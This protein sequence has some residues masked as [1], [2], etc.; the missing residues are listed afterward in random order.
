MTI[1]ELRDLFQGEY[2][3]AAQIRGGVK[4]DIGDKLLANFISQAQQ[5]IQRRLL[6][7][8]SSVDLTLASTTNVHSLPTNFGLHKHAYL[9]TS[10][11]EEKPARFMRELLAVGGTGN[12]FSIYQQGNTQQLITPHTSGTLTLFY[13]PDFRYYQ[14]SVSTSQDW[15]SFSGTVFTG[16]LM[17]PDRYDM[18]VLYYM[19]AKVIPE[20]EAK[21]EREIRSLKGS[22]VS[23]MD[24]SFGYE[25]GGVENAVVTL[26]TTGV[27][28]TSVPTDT[29]DK[30]IRFRVSDN[31]GDATVEYEGGWSTTP[32]IVNNTSTVVVT[33][34]DS[35]FTN[36]L[37]VES[38]N[39]DFSWALTGL[40]TITITPSPS[41]GWGDVEIIIEV[42]D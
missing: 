22:R 5:D 38:N 34:A 24:D 11:L 30:K 14:P 17:L 23:S 36:W 6:V 12:Y 10:L 16:K 18:A 31:G 8:E 4:I 9:G 2:T 28:S 32:T 39:E 35:E 29:A 13:Y 15:G 37:H 19:L 7:V 41:S 20:Y 3:L 42:W 25:L 33:S 40:T 27:S 21:Y 1:L 26:T